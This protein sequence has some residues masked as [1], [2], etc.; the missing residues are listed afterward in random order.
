MTSNNR[1]SAPVI[2]DHLP[3]EEASGEYSSDRK[4][5]K[6]VAAIILQVKPNDQFL[7]LGRNIPLEESIIHV[8]KRWMRL[9]CGCYSSSAE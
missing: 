7:H 2:N 1:R 9:I 5:I 6:K 3:I 4:K 8:Q